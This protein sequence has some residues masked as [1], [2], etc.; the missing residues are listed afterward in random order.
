MHQEAGEGSEL[1]T[2]WLIPIFD[3][4]RSSSSSS[5]DCIG[6]VECFLMGYFDILLFNKMNRALA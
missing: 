2:S 5:S 3:P 6:V 4:S 1:M